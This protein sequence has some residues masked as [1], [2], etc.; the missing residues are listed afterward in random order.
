VLAV[1]NALG[2]DNAATPLGI[3]AMEELDTLNR[4]TGILT[5]AQALLVAMNTAGMS[6]IP[7]SVINL[8][9]AAHSKDPYEIVAPTVLATVLS[10]AAAIAITKLLQRTERYRKQFETAE[11]RIRPPPEGK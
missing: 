2:L 10:M 6:I 8:R 7:V 11:D 3:K 5:D 4:K 9:L 1:A